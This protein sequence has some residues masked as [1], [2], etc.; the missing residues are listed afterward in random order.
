VFFNVK[1]C[2]YFLLRIVFVFAAA[3]AAAA[4]AADN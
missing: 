3:A 2:L 1:G 4:A